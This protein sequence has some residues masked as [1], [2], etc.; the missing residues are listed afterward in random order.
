M[1][2]HRAEIVTQ[3]AGAPRERGGDR[4][5]VDMTKDDRTQ[6]VGSPV[7][8]TAQT[9]YVARADHHLPRLLK[10]IVAIAVGATLGLTIVGAP[11][12][13]ILGGAAAAP[14]V[15]ETIKHTFLKA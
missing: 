3:A 13:V 12:S 1:L 11:F 8:V 15:I 4:K 10:E 6:E 2:K 5:M 7:Q 14:V 9:T